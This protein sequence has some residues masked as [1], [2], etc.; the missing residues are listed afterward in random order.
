MKNLFAF[1]L[2][3]IVAVACDDESDVTPTN[4]T[5][6][7]VEVD[8]SY[9]T[10]ELDNWVVVHDDD[11]RLL[12]SQSFESN[13]S[14]E[15][16]TDLTVSEKITVT[17]IGHYFRNGV[18]Y[19]SVF[20]YAKVDKGKTMVI[21][22]NF[23]NTHTMTG[24]LQV[25]ASDVLNYQRHS[26]SAGLGSSGSGS[27][28]SG[29]DILEMQ[30]NTYAGFSKYI[31]SISSGSEMRYK[32]LNN[33]QANES[34]N[35]S[36]NDML[37]FDKTVTFTF[38]TC[39]NATLFVNGSDP[40]LALTPNSFNLLTLFGSELRSTL[41]APYLNSL[42]NYVTG[43]TLT[44]V[45]YSLEYG[46]IGSIP[47][48]NITWPVKTDFVITASSLNDYS[49][50]ATKPYVWRTGTWQYFDATN[51]TNWVV[52]SPTD[53]QAFAELPADI[54]AQHPGLSPSKMVYKVSKI[55]TQAAPYDDYVDASFA[56]ASPQFLQG[57][58]IG[59]GL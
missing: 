7:N 36:F 56:S 42:T 20:S 1:A 22:T 10:D 9:E 32:V 34:Y 28:S 26:I 37:P 44:Y 59:I 21:K 12:A 19:Y 48:P 14:F 18:H 46:N 39:E 55:Y 53:E 57:V 4:T 49:I 29:T 6:L 23:G 43:L 3:V 2:I 25:T 17:T 38:P 52:Y 11:G 50:T 51:F 13:M 27:W 5:L 15:L 40:G 16:D 35:F 45:D 24:T 31:V 47:D 33:V 41:Q 54:V 8:G 30:T 58:T